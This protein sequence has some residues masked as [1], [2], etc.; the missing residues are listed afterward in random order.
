MDAEPAHAYGCAQARDNLAA[1]LEVERERPAEAMVRYPNLWRHLQGCPDCFAD[2]LAAR[3]LL[4]AEAAGEIPALALPPAR[5]PRRAIAAIK[6]IILT[7]PVLLRALPAVGALR[8]EPP[9]AHTLFDTFSQ[10]PP[11]RIVITVIEH[12]AQG[13]SLEVRVAPPIAGQV[14]LSAGPFQVEA[15]FQP[16]GSATFTGLPAMLFRETA[17]PDL[18]IRLV[19][20]SNEA[21]G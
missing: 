21:Q 9:A 16:D 4:A 7:R 5:S 1:L 17:A 12:P 19:P 11:G 2:Y 15:R 13:W 3:A 14:E 18:A 10:E 20:M 6:Q 8:G